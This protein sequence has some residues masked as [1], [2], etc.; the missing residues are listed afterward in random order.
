MLRD[1]TGCF[2]EPGSLR[3]M[4]MATDWARTEQRNKIGL[5]EKHPSAFWVF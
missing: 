2:K 1:R 4:V 3:W 5:L